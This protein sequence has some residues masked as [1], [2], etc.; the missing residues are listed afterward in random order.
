MGLM[1][2]RMPAAGNVDRFGLTRVVSR[3]SV[4]AGALG[5][6]MM[7]LLAACG[8]DDDD[9]SGS[10]PTATTA[11]AAPTATV[12]SE[13]ASPTQAETSEASA[14]AEGP[15][16][17]T[18]GR[19]VTVSLPKRPERIVT[20]AAAAGAL[21]DFGIR[22]IGIY[23]VQQASDGTIEP[24][25]GN[26]DLST[27][28]SIGE[29][30]DDIEIE[31]LLALEP[32]LVISTMNT[33][34]AIWGMQDEAIQ[35]LVED[36]VPVIA[37]PAFFEPID[38]LI[39]N[40]EELARALGGDPDSDEAVELRDAFVAA[41][42]DIRSI[43]AEKPDLAVV[44]CSGNEENFFFASTEMFPD[45]IYLESLGVQFIRPEGVEF[46]G[47]WGF[48]SWE[49]VGQYAPDALLV[50]SRRGWPPAAFAN[51]PTY[52]GLAAVKAE[53]IGKWTPIVPLSYGGMAIVL[54]GH[55]DLLRNADEDVA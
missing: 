54:E 49:Q 30:N 13:D 42:E 10:S 5:L 41:S 47:P 4:I 39:E 32:D 26:A 2:Q 28:T 27:M 36:V 17:F 1:K 8:G 14:E 50:D 21:W 35:S 11:A 15:W 51:Q 48:I 45:L 23:G 25:V 55:A 19:G 3:R 9:D 20:F 43:T 37:M 40:F 7:G 46:D 12:A 52:Q 33:L 22:P 34:N 31:K 6:G 44:V 38:G 18:D 24:T 16:E 53:Q 29:T